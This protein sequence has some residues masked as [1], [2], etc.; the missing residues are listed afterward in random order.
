MMI[1]RRQLFIQRYLH[2]RWLHSAGLNLGEKKNQWKSRE[3][4]L[5]AKLMDHKLDP[6]PWS[7]EFPSA[8]YVTESE[9]T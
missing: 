4:F 5:P 6:D 9:C 8:K 2:T 7:D 3:K 1:P